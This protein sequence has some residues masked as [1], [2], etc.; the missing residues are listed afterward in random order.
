ME[1]Q[2]RKG[3]SPTGDH[4]GGLIM[5]KTQKESNWAMCTHF[6]GHHKMVGLVRKQKEG[7]QVMSTHFLETTEGETC[8]DTESK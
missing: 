2:L 3:N 6:L 1:S 7:N 8:Q 5:I 4:R